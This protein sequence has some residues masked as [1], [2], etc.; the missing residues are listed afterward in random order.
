MHLDK[1][2]RVSFRIGE[3]KAKEKETNIEVVKTGSREVDEQDVEQQ[4]HM[5]EE[6]KK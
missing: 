2:F 4:K 5:A 6:K 1:V 3:S